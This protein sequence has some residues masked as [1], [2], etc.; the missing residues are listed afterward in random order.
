MPLKQE[1]NTMATTKPL[2]PRL[3]A[4]KLADSYEKAEDDLRKG[5]RGVQLR[6]ADGKFYASYDPSVVHLRRKELLDEA[7]RLRESY[8]QT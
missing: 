4:L 3:P 2:I 5:T 7:M 8:E 1:R 6:G